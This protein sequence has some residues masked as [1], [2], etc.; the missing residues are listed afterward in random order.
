MATDYIPA[1]YHSLT[2]YLQVN[3]AAAAIIFYQK[4]FGA[5]EIGRI[6]MGDGIIGHAEI[7][8]NGSRLML[9]EA[10]DKWGNKS[11][12]DLGGTPVCLCLY[13][14]DVD[15][16]FATALAAGATVKDGMEVKD[17]FYGDRSGS[18]TDPFGH[19]WTILTHKEDI[20]YEELQKRSDELCK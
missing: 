1:G 17:Q 2:P 8:I 11:P 19:I 12:R 13:V 20:S 10:S 16:V 14:K 9:A 3:D 4:A 6:N 5:K 7:E 18:L 15:S